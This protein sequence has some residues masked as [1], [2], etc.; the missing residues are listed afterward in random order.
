MPMLITAKLDSAASE[1]ERR[2]VQDDEFKK[3]LDS[4]IEYIIY[5]TE[6]K[7]RSSPQPLAVCIKL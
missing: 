2:F 3:D 1:D 6:K 5:K 7:F 4:M